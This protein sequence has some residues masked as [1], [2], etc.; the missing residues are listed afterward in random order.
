[1]QSN[2]HYNLW[3]FRRAAPLTRIRIFVL[4]TLIVTGL[5]CILYFADWWFREEH[6]ASWPMYLLLSF[7]F[8]W[9]IVRTMVVWS[10]YLSIR[11][12]QSAPSPDRLRTVA[13]FTTSSPGEPLSMFEKTLEACRRIR[14]PHTTY[15]LDDTRDS[16]FK[17]VAERYGAV[18]LELTDLPGAKAGKINAALKKTKEELILVMDPDHIPF[19]NFLNEVLGYFN[20]DKV[21]FVQVSQAYYNQY[22]SFTAAGAAEQTYGFYGPTQMGMHGHNCAVAIGANCT[23]RRNALESIGGHGI[24]LAEDLVTSIRIHAAG[25]KSIYAPVIVSRGL[26]PEDLGSF[27]KQ[28]LKWARG[29][30][31]V[32][33]AE[34]PQHWKNLSS[35]QR[36]SYVTI[37]TY[38]LS[39]L[40]VLLFLLIPFFYLWLGILP[41]HMDFSAFLV[42]WLP[43]GLMSL[44]IYLYMQQWLC[45]PATEKGIHWRG[46]VLKFTCWPVFLAGFWLSILNRKVPYI[47]TAKR[48]IQGFTPFVRPL[49]VHAMIFITTLVFIIMQRG[50]YTPE[51][52]LTLTS[53]DIWGMMVFAAIPFVLSIGGIYAAWRSRFINIEDPWAEVNLEA[54][55][56][57][58]QTRNETDNNP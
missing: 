58:N 48:A 41:A 40:M 16:R 7:L 39:G 36:I 20:D 55:Q 44:T 49:F 21:G 37:G 4:S 22:R 8:W 54:I 53:P 15:L 32:L 51:A 5:W 52:R 31:E 45:H 13:I 38:Y 19:P 57:T 10:S 18:W 43:V 28:Q 30:H 17:E 47:P 42:H 12:P 33:F 14:Y 50:F 24:G 46:M 34:L 27:C 1:V 6:V 26:V 3:T 9:S 29:V 11:Q 35:W 2:P 23:F 25:W 56:F